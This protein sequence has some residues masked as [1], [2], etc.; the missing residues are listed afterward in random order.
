MITNEYRLVGDED[1]HYS[2]LI[3]GRLRQTKPYRFTFD[4]NDLPLVKQHT[5]T[6]GSKKYIKC[7]KCGVL[8]HRI[9]MNPPSHKIVDH[10]NR[11]PNNNR[12]S[13]LRIATH[14]QN[15]W[16]SKVVDNSIIP[17]KGLTFRNG[18]WRVHITRNN[19]KRNLGS[20]DHIY[21]ATLCRI[22]SEYELY[23][24]FSLNYRSILNKIPKKYLDIWLPE[25]YS[26]YN[27]Q[28][29]GS[30][31]WKAHY[32]NKTNKNSTHW[33]IKSAQVRKTGILM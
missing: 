25:I 29:I 11:C 7:S 26:K 4:L 12:R 14:S 15:T 22:R 27:V 23:G 20:Y 2:V 3:F 24:E 9:I 18:K 5:W 33:G 10:V 13:N 19:I 21:D 17:V 32:K 28:Y 1:A 30:D 8:L 6:V 16:N 31:I